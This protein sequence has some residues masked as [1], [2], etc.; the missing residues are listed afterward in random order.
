[1]DT[2]LYTIENK[3]ISRV[4]RLYTVGFKSLYEKD[5]LK[6]KNLIKNIKNIYLPPE[7]CT[8]CTSVY[9]K[10]KIRKDD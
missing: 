8:A 5:I 6:I 3:G 7:P 4:T 9:K 1:M 10:S 2:V